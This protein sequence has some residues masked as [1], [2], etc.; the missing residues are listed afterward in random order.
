M[1]LVDIYVPSIDNTYDF[2]LDENVELKFIV[3]ELA[4]MI[5]KKS[6]NT[7]VVHEGFNLYSKDFERVL[8]M[9]STLFSEGIRDGSKLVFL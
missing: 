6:G 8:R 2:S 5:S 4:E 9:D 1:I 3:T 7:N